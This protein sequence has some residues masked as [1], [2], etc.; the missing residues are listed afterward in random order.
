MARQAIFQFSPGDCARV[1][2]CSYCPG[3]TPRYI[4]VELFGETYTLGK[5]HDLQEQECVWAKIFPEG[6]RPTI[7]CGEAAEIWLV[8]SETALGDVYAIL[9]VADVDGVILHSYNNI[10]DDEVVCADGTLSLPKVGGSCGGTD[11]AVLTAESASG[12]C[13]GN[14]GD[15][16]S[17]GSGSGGGGGPAVAFSVPRNGS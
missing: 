5:K 1:C 2:P 16:G 4:D 11:E 7:D 9:T 15:E 17:S 10:G 8:F 14:C 6:S 3:T 12:N 13:C